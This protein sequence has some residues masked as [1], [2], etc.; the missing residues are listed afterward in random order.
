[1]WIATLFLECYFVAVWHIRSQYNSS[2]PITGPQKVT[3]KEEILA[4]FQGFLEQNFY[5]AQVMI[6]LIC[7]EAELHL[8]WLQLR[9]L[10]ENTITIISNYYYRYDHDGLLVDNLS[11][12]SNTQTRKNHGFY[13]KEMYLI[14]QIYDRNIVHHHVEGKDINERSW[15]AVS[16]SFQ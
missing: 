15:C 2:D 16:I 11:I 14:V 1:M 6:L 3:H 5:Q 8:R 13:F 7:W 9:F 10:E 12:C 4:I